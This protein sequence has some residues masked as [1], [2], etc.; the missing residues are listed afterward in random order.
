VGLG[1]AA[2]GDCCAGL[3]IRRCCKPPWYVYFRPPLVLLPVRPPTWP[4]ACNST[5]LTALQHCVPALC[6]CV[7]VYVC[8]C[9]R[10]Q[11]G[12]AMGDKRAVTAE[13]AFYR[14]FQ[15]VVVAG[16]GVL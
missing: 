3:Q 11:A 16:S 8:V 12:K 6:V 15:K 5:A 14:P 1:R 13:R 10:S 9:A 2:G 7:C 4:V